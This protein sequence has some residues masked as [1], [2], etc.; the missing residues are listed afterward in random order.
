MDTQDGLFVPVMRGPLVGRGI[1]GFDHSKIAATATVLIPL[2]MA[3]AGMS[4]VAAQAL[5]LVLLHTDQLDRG[6]CG[7]VAPW[8]QTR[9][10]AATPG[11]NRDRTEALFDKFCLTGGPT[12]IRCR[13]CGL[14][15]RFSAGHRS[16][17]GSWLSC[18]IGY[19]LSASRPP[20]WWPR[21]MIASTIR[22]SIRTRNGCRPS[23]RNSIMNTRPATALHH[24]PQ[25]MPTKPKYPAVLGL[26]LTNSEHDC[27]APH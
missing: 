13:G 23:D 6:L 1:V 26:D 20:H 11:E 4:S 22:R 25:P 18:S 8:R 9:S 5:A 2:P 27:S 3:N 14:L 21:R 12:G 10:I 16:V 17:D 7:S 24:G 19:R 15:S